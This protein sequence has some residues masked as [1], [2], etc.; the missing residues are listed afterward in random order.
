[1]LAAL[2][3]ALLLWL[4]LIDVRERRLP[5]Q[6]VLAVAVLGLVT[7]VVRSASTADSFS[8]LM[9]SVLLGMLLSAGP[10]LALSLIYQLIR[11]RG[12]FGAGDIKLLAAL[13]IYFGPAGLYLLP[14]ACV[15]ASVVALLT[16]IC[17]RV[18][19]GDSAISHKHS[20]AFGPYI[21][22]AALLLLM[23]QMLL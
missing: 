5:N 4:S 23:L 20:I 10:A 22:L 6:L 7:H 9:H 21:A 17:Q 11:G 8:S 16:Y 13:G 18:T 12:G 2:L 15:L 1:V 3:L 14:I 19:A